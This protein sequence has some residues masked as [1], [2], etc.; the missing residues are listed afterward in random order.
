MRTNAIVLLLVV[1]AATNLRSQTW[2][3]T[4]PMSVE[5]RMLTLT[6]LEDNTVLA[7]GGADANN[8][9][10]ATCELYDPATAS[11]AMTA[12]MK[13]PPLAACQSCSGERRVGRKCLPVVRPAMTPSATPV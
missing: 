1:L 13:T 8:R 11:W 9:S 5:R 6:V 2:Q 10:L 12:S 3:Y 7:I 4:A